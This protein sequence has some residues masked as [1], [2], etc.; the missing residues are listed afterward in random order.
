MFSG[1]VHPNPSAVAGGSAGG[2]SHGRGTGR[3]STNQPQYYPINLVPHPQMSMRLYQNAQHVYGQPM[4]HSG[5]PGNML[6]A[7]GTQVG[8]M[9]PAGYGRQVF[10]L[11]NNVVPRPWALGYPQGSG[12]MHSGQFLYSHSQVRPRPV[13]YS[14]PTSREPTPTQSTLQSSSRQQVAPTGSQTTPAPPGADYSLST[15]SHVNPGAAVVSTMNNPW[16]LP[17][18][19]TSWSNMVQRLQFNSVPC[20]TASGRIHTGESNPSLVAY[21]APPSSVTAEG[22]K[23]VTRTVPTSSTPLTASQPGSVPQRTPIQQ[24]AT[25]VT[26]SLVRAFPFTVNQGKPVSIITRQPTPSVGSQQ[27]APPTTTRGAAEG[28]TPEST[29]QQPCVPQPG[30]QLGSDVSVAACA[31]QSHTAVACCAVRAALW[32]LPRSFGELKRKIWRNQNN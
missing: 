3:Y 13:S 17:V 2:S 15:S 32:T 31:Q 11:R 21:T 6:S 4:A 7:Y 12:N 22:M 29:Q 14:I 1:A 23:S 19:D 18:V 20:T 5:S 16:S 9:M 10:P 30:S 8:P 27:Q 26:P 25:Q 24:E 28:L